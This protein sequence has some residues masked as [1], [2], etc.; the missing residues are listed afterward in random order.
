MLS[1]ESLLNPVPSTVSGNEDSTLTPLALSMQTNVQVNRQTSVEELYH[2]AKNTIVEYPKTALGVSSIGHLFEMDISKEWV[3]PSRSFAYSLGKPDGSRRFPAYTDL[4]LASDGTPVPCNVRYSTCELF[5]ILHLREQTHTSGSRF[6]RILDHEHEHQGANNSLEQALM[7]K[8]LAYWACLRD[9]GCGRAL[10]QDTVYEP[11]EIEYYNAIHDS[12]RK[13]KRGHVSKATCEGRIVLRYTSADKPYL[14]CEHFNSKTSRK[15]FCDF[16]IGHDVYHTDYLLAL[17]TANLEEI[18]KW[19]KRASN[20]GYGPL[21]PCKT[22]RNHSTVCIDCPQQHR[23]CDGTMYMTEMI[24]LS[25]HCIFHIYEP[26][27]D[28]CRQCPKVLVICSGE[29]THPIPASTKTP[30][31]LRATIL[32]LLCT[33]MVKELPEM[34]PRQF[35]RHPVVQDFIRSQVPFIRQPQLSDVH[36]SLNNN[37]HLRAYISQAQKVVFPAGTGWE[38]KQHCVYSLTSVHS[39]MP[40][41]LKHLHLML[42]VHSWFMFLHSTYEEG[43]EDDDLKFWIVICMFPQQSRALLKAQFVQ[44]DISYKRVAGFK[45]LEFVGWDDQSHTTIVYCRAFMTRESAAAHL[46]FFRMLDELLAVKF[47]TGETL[48]F[49]HLH[50]KSLSS[51]SGILHWA[52]DQGRGAAKGMA[53]YFHELAS[54]LPPQARD[55]HQPHRLLR[56][57]QPYEHLHRIARLCTA[58]INRNIGDSKKIPDFIKPCMRSLM[59]VAHPNWDATIQEIEN[60]N[61]IADKISSK[62]AFEAMCQQKSFIP[63]DIW[64]AGPATTNLVESAHWNIYLEGLE[65]SLLNAVTKGEYLDHLKMTS[66]QVLT[67]ILLIISKHWLTMDELRHIK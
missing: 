66:W 2:Y 22:V 51:Y 65:C 61:W 37:D 44:S 4:L 58:H 15:H 18:Y 67:K 23:A 64:Q 21:S 28:F 11:H 48:K 57:L 62:F 16:S 38:G 47:Y 29:H 19:E 36:P 8:T 9:N 10:Q 34:T 50:S 60:S 45:E 39:L 27:P 59:C 54:K 49:R 42:T 26:L 1:W 41:L 46:V 20:L 52:I 12:P 43:F 53:L 6:Y 33:S 13:K 32:D 40:L 30:P 24:T 35:L 3:S 25:C 31:E 56:D 14:C 55:L 63:L 5:L 7:E 17:C